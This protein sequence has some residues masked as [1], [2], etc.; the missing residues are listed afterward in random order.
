[1]ENR[2]RERNWCDKYI[3]QVA[4]VP[5]RELAAG[6]CFASQRSVGLR[7]RDIENTL[8]LAQADPPK[9]HPRRKHLPKGHTSREFTRRHNGNLN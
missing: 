1:M 2:M 3:T 9:G 6:L 4:I 5:A 7:R 8:S